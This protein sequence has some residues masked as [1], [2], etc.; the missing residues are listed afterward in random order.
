MRN[1]RPD[2]FILDENMKVIPV[3]DDGTNEGLFR[4]GAWLEQN[5]S[6]HVGQH[7]FDWNGQKVFVS[8]IF[9]ALD[10][11]Y[12]DGP[13]ILWET[14]VFGGPEEIDHYQQRCGGN[15]EQAQAMHME[16]VAHVKTTLKIQDDETSKEATH[17]SG[18][19]LPPGVH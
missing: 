11:R 8:T 1:G 17:R 12:G 15:V 13:P 3:Y 14:M 16:V 7:E 19:G 18:E 9:L 5:F 4:W 6:R 2:K 10:H